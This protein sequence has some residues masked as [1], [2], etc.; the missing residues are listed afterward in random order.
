[1][2]RIVKSLHCAALLVIVALLAGGAAPSVNKDRDLYLA[3][4]KEYD[5]VGK[6]KPTAQTRGKWEKLGERL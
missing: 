2:P 1:M 3:A 6:T 4:K 5:V